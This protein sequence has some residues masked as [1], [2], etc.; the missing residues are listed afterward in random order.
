M[1]V[2]FCNS[3]KILQIIAFL[4]NLKRLF[5][6]YLPKKNSNMNYY[7]RSQN[8]S[9]TGGMIAIRKPKKSVKWADLN[10]EKPL[11]QIRLI[12]VVGKGRKLP[13]RNT[14]NIVTN[15]LQ[16]NKPKVIVNHCQVRTCPYFGQYHQPN[17]MR[18]TA[19]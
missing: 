13:N 16:N 12:D 8:K 5:Y 11:Q 14:N 3:T 19:V 2:S 7:F 10:L 9:N 17:S 18:Q 6:F 1:G 15:N 4:K